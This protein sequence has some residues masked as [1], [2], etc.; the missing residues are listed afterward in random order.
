MYWGLSLFILY[1][2]PVLNGMTLRVLNSAQL[3]FNYVQHI[4]IYIYTYIY[5]VSV[6][7]LS[8][9]RIFTM[10]LSH[11]LIMH[12]VQSYRDEASAKTPPALLFLIPMLDGC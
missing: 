8:I 7:I 6:D 10:V 1:G 9:T 5:N 11:L 2:H 12:P 4:Y 3:V